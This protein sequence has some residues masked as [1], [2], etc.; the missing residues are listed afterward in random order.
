MLQKGQL[1]QSP[2][3]GIFY[4]VRSVTEVLASV[5]SVRPDGEI[6]R[7]VYLLCQKEVRLVGNN[8]RPKARK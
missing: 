8:Y 6:S 2:Y 3:T 1:V 5:S 7:N 4:L